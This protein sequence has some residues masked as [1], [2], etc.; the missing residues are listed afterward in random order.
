MT[1]SWSEFEAHCV[2][3]LC[4][5]GLVQAR[6]VPFVIAELCPFVTV[7]FRSTVSRLYADDR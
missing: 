6:L 2:T 7:E 4:S 5:V 3:H 1:I